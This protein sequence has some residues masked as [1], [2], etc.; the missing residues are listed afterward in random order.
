MELAGEL[1]A[2]RFFGGINSLQFA[3]PAIDRELEKAEALKDIY[4]MNAAD[5]ASPAGLAVTGIETGGNLPSRIASSRLCYRGSELIALSNRGGKDIRIFT[6]ADDPILPEAL[7]FIR[8][9]KTRAVSPENKIIIERI[10]GKSA[11]SGDYGAIFK[12]M[13]FVSDRGRLILW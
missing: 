1:I 12:E 7:E 9:S 13:G 5:P 8:I 6:A 2:G 3:S 10:N 11:A 4:W